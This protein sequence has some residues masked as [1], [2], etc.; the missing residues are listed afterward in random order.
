MI[1]RPL[2]VSISLALACGG[3]G[4][5]GG[6]P[7]PV[8]FEISL[9]GYVCRGNQEKY[10]VADADT[11]PQ[12][13]ERCLSRFGG[14]LVKV[15]LQDGQVHEQQAND[16]GEYSFEKLTVSGSNSDSITFSGVGSATAIISNLGRIDPTIGPGHHRLYVVLP[17]AACPIPDAKG[18]SD[19][20]PGQL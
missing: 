8:V 17:R 3:A 10:M 15:E 9:S 19:A 20:S 16:Q 13:T 4:P 7:E 2:V 14:A 18:S 1:R 12:F 5:A 6:P 11:Y